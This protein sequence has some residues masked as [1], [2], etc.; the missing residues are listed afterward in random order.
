MKFSLS[1]LTVFFIVEALLC[2][3]RSFVKCILRLKYFK[4][5]KRMG[6]LPIS[7]QNQLNQFET[8]FPSC[9]PSIVILV[10]VDILSTFKYLVVGSSV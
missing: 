5:D 4:L 9:S 8:I 6:L 3:M 1:I 2:Y 7:S 10:F